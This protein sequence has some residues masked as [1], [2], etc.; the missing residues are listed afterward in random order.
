MCFCE[1]C[2]L[3]CVI[4]GWKVVIIVCL[5]IK[6]IVLKEWF[7]IGCSIIVLLKFLKFGKEGSFVS[8]VFYSCGSNSMEK[9]SI[10]K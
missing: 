10:F 6:I 2:S 5:W 7:Y 3:V 8:W 1:S 9:W 4:K